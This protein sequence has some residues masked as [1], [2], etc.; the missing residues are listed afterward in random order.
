VGEVLYDL[1]NCIGSNDMSTYFILLV[2][3]RMALKTQRY[4]MGS[5]DMRN[6]FVAR[7]SSDLQERRVSRKSL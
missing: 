3:A 7:C 4:G 5:L 6:T 2:A 1:T